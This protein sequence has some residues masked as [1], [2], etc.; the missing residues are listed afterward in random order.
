MTRY[1]AGTRPGITIENTRL[2]IRLEETGSLMRFDATEARWVDDGALFGMFTG[3]IETDPI[4]ES[5]A[6]AIITRILAT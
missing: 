1:F 3:D 2:V 6:Q 5:Q 4:T